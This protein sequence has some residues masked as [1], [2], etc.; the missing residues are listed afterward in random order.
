[1]DVEANPLRW[2]QSES[3]H[4]HWR[5]VFYIGENQQFTRVFFSDG[6]L[7]VTIM[8]TKLFYGSTKPLEC[9]SKIFYGSIKP[10][11]S[12]TKL[13]YGSTKPSESPKKICLGPQ[14]RQRV[15]QNCYVGPQIIG[16]SNKFILWVNKTIE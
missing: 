2:K 1:M 3:L 4:F 13:F 5:V 14:T 10:S 6:Y 11:K 9:L 7:T 12:P 8:G 15:Q 16:D